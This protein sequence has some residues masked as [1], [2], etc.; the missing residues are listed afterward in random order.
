[1]ANIRQIPR[2][3]PVATYKNGVQLLTVLGESENLF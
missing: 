1:M 3:D 2:D